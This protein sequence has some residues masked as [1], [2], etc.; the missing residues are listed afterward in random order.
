MHRTFTTTDG[1]VIS[2]A[3]EGKGEVLLLVHGWS[4]SA[5]MF[6]HQIEHFSKS[7]RVI[8]PDFRGH[9]RSPNPGHGFRIYRLAQDL[10]EL[11]EHEGIER[12]SVLG[13]SM[14]SSV[15]WAMIDLYGTGWIDRLVLVDEPA[16]VMRQPGM[17]DEAAANAGALF[18][19]ATMVAIA[20]QIAGPDGHAT[21]EGF[22]GG[23][24]TKGIAPDLRAFLLEENLRVDPR[25][26]AALFINHCTIDWSEIFDRID[27]PTLVIGGRVSHVNPQSQEWISGRI[28]G[29]RLVLFDEAEGG[30]HFP[31]LESP[32][33]F[34]RVVDGFLS[35]SD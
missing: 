6:R 12:A 21:R 7:R 28:A 16:S 30:A 18:D 5:A 15:V 8:A 4:Q 1:A 25:Q 32:E 35:G 13:W 3:D 19:A 17:S 34:N 2:Y 11:L 10:R 29:S 23:M 26:V 31:F 9:G 22:L 24:I 20:E 14:G 33:S 27:R